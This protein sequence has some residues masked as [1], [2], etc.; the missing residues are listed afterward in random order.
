MKAGIPPDYRA[1]LSRRS[2]TAPADSGG[3]SVTWR[4]VLVGCL[5]CALIAVGAPYGRQIVK[6]TAL[7]LTSA[8][9]AALFLLF[10][11]LLTG[12][13]LLGWCRRR[14]AF[15]RGE[16][17]TAFTMMTVAAA[18]PTKGVVGMLLPII[19]GTFYHA[20]PENKWA[21][22]VHP[23]LAR[24]IL[25]DDVEAV[26]GFYEGGAD[27]PWE[28]WLP[29]LAAWLAFYLA[30]YLTLICLSTI[31]RRQWVDHERLAYPLVQAPLAMIDE[32]GEDG[33]L[34]PFFRNWI[35]WA[36]FAIPF[37]L[38][39]L[40]ALHH[41]FP[42]LA[43]PALTT[44]V[45]LLDG[46]RSLRLS[47]NFLILGLAYFIN[48]N[49]SLSLW[50]FYLVS[51]FQ[52]AL[53]GSMGIHSNAD[54][55]HW[56]YPIRGH[57]M[58]GAI[59]VLLGAVLWTGRGHFKAVLRRA[60]DGAA[61]VD[62]RGEIMPFRAA[63][64]GCAVGLAGLWIWLWQTGIPAW[65]APIILAVG[66]TIFV[67]LARIIAETGL[68]IVKPTM[69][70]AG[71][72]LSGVGSSA[73]GPQGTVALGYTM[74]WCGDLLVFMMA[75]LVNGLRLGS[76]LKSGQRRLFWALAAA[77]LLTW[78]LSLWYTLYLAYR[79]GSINMYI[80]THYATEPSRLA[81]RHLL[82]PTGPSLS[83]WLWTGG[84]G[85]VMGLLLAARRYLLWWPLHPLGF[86]V[87]FGRVMEGIWFTV[88]LAWLA[89]RFILRLGGAA[90]YRKM[91]PFF[92]GIALGHICAGGVWLVIDGL[93]GTVGNRIPLY[94]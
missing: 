44:A 25:V 72:T 73:L 85:L 34:K 43:A 84:G 5:L 89:K 63:V 7:A 57:Q 46:G 51:Y 93:T 54:L 26:R 15:S 9:P 49:I 30:F 13:L 94:Y 74:V 65:I 4:G 24:W 80:S 39:S 86:V 19:T 58:M 6:G 62:D 60:W 12:H 56:S 48:L 87:S 29:P 35:M 79:H 32:G 41:Y 38:S 20:S 17:I 2:T 92:L 52:D 36:G 16:L 45:Q 66:L 69:I 71:F 91:Q 21:A 64:V 83:G 78:V 88:F 27:I 53:F 31:L 67:V 70:P 10:V 76:E 33:L 61:A 23:L 37:F 81:A 28:H 59:A 18:I 82:D 75:P 1:Y 14:W 50:L 77:M 3:A 40:V 22:Q 8:T 42:Q 47:I 11:L 68:P 55:G 90:A